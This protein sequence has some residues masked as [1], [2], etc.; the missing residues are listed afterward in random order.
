MQTRITIPPP[1]DEASINNPVPNVFHI[2]P[3]GSV[4]PVNYELREAE[5]MED[6]PL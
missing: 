5:A 2:V 4:V 6:F 1:I 3:D